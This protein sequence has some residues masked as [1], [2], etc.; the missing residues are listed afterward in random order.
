MRDWQ[1]KTK[2]MRGIEVRRGNGGVHMTR[3]HDNHVWK[4]HNKNYSYIELIDSN[5]TGNKKC[6]LRK[7]ETHDPKP[8]SY[9]PS[10]QGLNGRIMIDPRPTWATEWDHVSKKTHGQIMKEIYQWR[11]RKTPSHCGSD[12]FSLVWLRVYNVRH[13]C[14]AK[15]QSVLQNGKHLFSLCS[16][17]QKQVAPWVQSQPGLLHGLCSQLAK[18]A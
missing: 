9:N 1:G 7:K 6:S 17:G 3:V 10:S 5:W 8:R 13:K 4:C 12:I 18:A 2:R 14:K 16:Q 15:I 11:A